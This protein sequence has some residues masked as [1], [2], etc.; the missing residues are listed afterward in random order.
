[1]IEE[2]PPTVALDESDPRIFRLSAHERHVL[3]VA[4]A[5]K[6]ADGFV[7]PADLTAAIGLQLHHAERHLTRFRALGF[8]R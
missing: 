8:F 7:G 3:A 6:K 1:M 2:P 5:I 4:L